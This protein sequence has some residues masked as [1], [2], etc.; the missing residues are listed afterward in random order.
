MCERSAYCE[1]LFGQSMVAGFPELLFLD[2]KACTEEEP[3]EDLVQL[4]VVIW[5]SVV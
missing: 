1:L 2:F 5:L 3:I 4:H